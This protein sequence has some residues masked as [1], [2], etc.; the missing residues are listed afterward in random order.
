MSELINSNHHENLEINEINTR[1]D[2]KYFSNFTKVK[3]YHKIKIKLF[4]HV[5][6]KKIQLDGWHNSLS[7]YIIKCEKHGYQLTYPVGWRKRLI[8]RECLT[9]SI[10]NSN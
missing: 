4:G 3:L 10:N 9:E 7:S 5:F 1:E 8:C 2:I 6:F